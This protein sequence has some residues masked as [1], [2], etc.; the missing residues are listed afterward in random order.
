M[1]NEKTFGNCYNRETVSSSATVSFADVAHQTL[2]FDK[3]DPVSEMLLKLVDTPWVQ[4]LRQI[5]QTG[6][7]HLLYM[8]AE[9]SRFGHSLGVAYLATTLMQSLSR[10]AHKM[11]EPYR[12]AVAAAALL[13]DI[14]HTA[15][16]S[17]LAEKVWGIDQNA[18]KHEQVSMRVISE[19][20]RI[21]GILSARSKTLPQTVCQI[22]D[23]DS[24]L[25]SWTHA[26]ISGGGWNAD[27]GN[28][29]IVDSAMCS[30]S[31]GRY[32]V[33]ALLDAFRLSNSGELVIQ[34]N[35]LDALTHFFVARDSMYRQVYQHR[36][37]LGADA[38][39]LNVVKRLREIAAPAAG[40]ISELA[41]LFSAQKIYADQT[42]LA[43]LLAP[44]YAAQ[45]SLEQIF[46]MTESW[47]RYHLDHWCLADDPILKD[48]ALRVR[49][50]NLFK[51]IR[52]GS[53][54]SENHRQLLKQAREIA[55]DLKLNPDYYV[56]S[57]ESSD[58]HRSKT[59]EAPQ[60]MLDS[61]E[62]VPVTA[63]EPLIAKLFEKTP[64]ERSWIAVPKEIKDRI[65]KVR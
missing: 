62:L 25:P 1:I 43:A 31:Y 30:V 65:G 48:M 56:I 44:N 27:R 32:N 49:D 51:T 10:Y 19:D 47:W 26:I 52:T 55:A 2:I 20:P 42:M 57:I 18:N 46:N 60:V 61:G 64:L 22:L 29:A 4:R 45:L 33:S 40:N 8:F 9:H 6:N 7:T 12:D 16:G 39:I 53:G 34:E 50:R 23:E 54:G 28:W 38:L 21:N 14:G 5:R 3:A 15:P 17:H 63:V 36:V 41:E 58:R 37:L 13:H 11:V 24:K 35:R 59:E